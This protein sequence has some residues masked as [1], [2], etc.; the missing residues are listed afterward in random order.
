MARRIITEVLSPVSEQAE[1]V[2]EEV[3]LNP[4]DEPSPE[5]QDAEELIRLGDLS[6]NDLSELLPVKTSLSIVNMGDDKWTGILRP[7]PKEQPRLMMPGYTPPSQTPIVVQGPSLDHALSGAFAMMAP[8]GIRCPKCG[9]FS[10]EK[11]IQ[12]SGTSKWLECATCGKR[13]KGKYD[14]TPEEV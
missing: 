2:I 13:Y 9:E 12:V 8:E 6:L 5:E 7:V 11:L 14:A 3:T 10:I 1:E 4:G